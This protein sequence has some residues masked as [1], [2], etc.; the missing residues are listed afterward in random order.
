MRSALDRLTLV[1]FLA[2]LSGVVAC[3]RAVRAAGDAGAPL[4]TFT[5]E[6]LDMTTVYAMRAGGIATRL[7]SV[8]PGR[9]DTLSIPETMVSADQIT[10]V[11]GSITGTPAAS[12]G[13]LSLGPGIRLAITLLPSQSVLRVIPI[14]Q[15]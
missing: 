6:S 8:M 15:S 5:N 1:V 10:I 3:S 9:T 11:A 12:S 4:L 13:P 14:P 2:A 7:A